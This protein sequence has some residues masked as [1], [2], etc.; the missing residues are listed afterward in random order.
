MPKRAREH[1]TR[2]GVLLHILAFRRA[3]QNR[4]L[5]FCFLP[6]SLGGKSVCPFCFLLILAKPSATP[7]EW[8]QD[9][10]R[11]K[12]GQK[13]CGCCETKKFAPH[14]IL[15]LFNIPASCDRTHGR[16][17]T[18]SVRAVPPTRLRSLSRQTR[19]SLA[20]EKRV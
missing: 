13:F 6:R 20:T 16:S 14:R 10:G 1:C 17:A 18:V 7:K 19:H 3:I 2:R 8:R 4:T 12:H 9:I 5:L 15:W 11:Q